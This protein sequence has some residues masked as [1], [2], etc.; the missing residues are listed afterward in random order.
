LRIG[1]AASDDIVIGPISENIES[2]CFKGKRE[3]SRQAF[4]QRLRAV[5]PLASVVADY[6]LNNSIKPFIKSVFSIR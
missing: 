2:G 4:G 3:P 5:C 6:S 1:I